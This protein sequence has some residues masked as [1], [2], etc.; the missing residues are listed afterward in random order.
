MV[1]GYANKPGKAE[2]LRQEA[3]AVTVGLDEIMTALRLTPPAAVR[4]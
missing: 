1:V 3:D 2:L 4:G